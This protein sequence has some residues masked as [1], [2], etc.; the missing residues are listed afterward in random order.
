MTK[1]PATTFEK[2]LLF[3]CNMLTM[4][5]LHVIGGGKSYDLTPY[6]KPLFHLF[7]H[8]GVLCLL[9]TA[10]FLVSCQKQP[11][12]DI[13]EGHPV[14]YGYYQE[15]CHLWKDDIKTDSV[16]RFV[17]KVDDYITKYPDGRNTSYYPGL[18]QNTKNAMVRVNIIIGGTVWDPDTI[19]INFD[20]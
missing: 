3:A 17:L 4:S 2:H 11:E 5:M 13:T 15:S 6:R 20:F 14:L 8:I 7:C 16:K 12:A 10:P 9:G 19:K 1:K 18:E